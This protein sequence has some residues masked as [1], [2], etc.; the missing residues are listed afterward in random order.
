MKTTVSLKKEVNTA[1]QCSLTKRVA[2]GVFRAARAAAGVAQAAPS[3]LAH[4]FDEVRD[5]WV[6]TR[7]NV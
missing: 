6:E 4:S 5:A 7:P 1:P 2:L 3:R